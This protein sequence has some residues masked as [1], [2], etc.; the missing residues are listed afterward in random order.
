MVEYLRVPRERIDV[1]P[2]APGVSDRAH[3]D[4][5]AQSCGPVSGWATARWS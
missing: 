2:L 5:G 3:A 4:P 1:V